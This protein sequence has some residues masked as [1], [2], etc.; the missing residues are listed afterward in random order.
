[1]P[2]SNFQ[3]KKVEFRI[4]MITWN[5][6]LSKRNCVFGKVFSS[7]FQWFD[8]GCGFLSVAE[9]KYVIPLDPCV[10]GSKLTFLLSF[11]VAFFPAYAILP[12]VKLNT[13]SPEHLYQRVIHVCLV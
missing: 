9:S 10:R 4:F 2:Y 1:M 8:L 11:F 5:E 7:I 13:V 3:A 12:H 6:F